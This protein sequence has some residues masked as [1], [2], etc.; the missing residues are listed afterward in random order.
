MFNAFIMRD[1]EVAEAA[2]QKVL[3]IPKENRIFQLN[4]FNNYFCMLAQG[5]VGF[6]LGKEK[7]NRSY[8][9][10]AIQTLHWFKERP[11]LNTV[12]LRLWLEAYEATTEHRHVLDGT[13]VQKMWQNVIVM[14]ARS[15]LIH[16]GAMANELLADF[17]VSC[18]EPQDAHGTAQLH[19]KRAMDLYQEWGAIVKVEALCR[20][21]NVSSD[22]DGTNNITSNK[23]GSTLRGRERFSSRIDAASKSQVQGLLV[24]EVNGSPES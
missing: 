5:L 19:V 18:Q 10:H 11:N 6:W 9:K 12:P 23:T 15:G 3:S 21:H 20:S 16:Y 14:L 13:K 8:R 1:M 4:Y 22:H 24:D 7:H 2:F 17:L